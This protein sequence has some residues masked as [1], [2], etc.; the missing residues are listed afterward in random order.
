MKS[1]AI[2]TNL[3]Y[4]RIRKIIGYLGAFLPYM[5]AGVAREWLPSVSD[6]YYSVSSVIFT[7]TLM[8]TG[9]FLMS[10]RGYQ[11][12]NEVFTDNIITNIG[13]F[14]LVIVA[15]VP[16]PYYGNCIDEIC[17]VMPVCH[18]SNGWGVVHFFSASGFFLLMAYLSL[19]HFTRGSEEG[20]RESGKQFRNIIYRVCGIG[21]ISVLAVTAFV[22]FVLEAN[23]FHN[24]TYWMEAIMLFFF[25]IS[26][27]VKG[28]GLTDVH[29]QTEKENMTETEVKQ[30]SQNMVLAIQSVEQ[31]N[32]LIREIEQFMLKLKKD[33]PG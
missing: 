15:F 31:G 13:G 6:Y 8:L 14:L 1:V 5:V 19:F 20:L 16:T 24:F 32:Q 29:L 11:D 25:G 7:G 21:I 30:L 23:V 2:N 12:P 22:I 18:C 9:V 28:K 4:F 10:Y 27:W 3:S 26:W 33:K 17:E